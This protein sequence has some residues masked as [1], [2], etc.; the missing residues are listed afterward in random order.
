ML[1]AWSWSAETV[2]GKNPESGAGAF[3]QSL[4]A[5]GVDRDFHSFTAAATRGAV[6]A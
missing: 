5:T 4:K 1:R 2:K 3:P 6:T